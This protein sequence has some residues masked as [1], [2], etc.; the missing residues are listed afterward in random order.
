MRLR[1]SPYPLSMLEYKNSKFLEDFSVCSALETIHAEWVDASRTYILYMKKWL[2]QKQTNDTYMIE[3]CEKCET[4]LMDMFQR[5]NCVFCQ[6]DECDRLN[7]QCINC[8]T[9]AL[10]YVQVHSLLHLYSTINLV[11]MGK[12]SKYIL[13]TNCLEKKLLHSF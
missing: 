6:C 3:K 8:A 9:D 1:P 7:A 12:K 5:R 13:C 2:L 4:G 11:K 10:E